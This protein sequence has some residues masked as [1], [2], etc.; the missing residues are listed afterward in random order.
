MATLP[1]AWSWIPPRHVWSNF[2]RRW[3]CLVVGVFASKVCTANGVMKISL[4]FALLGFP[5]SSTLL[6]WYLVFQSS[7]ESSDQSEYGY[8]RPAVVPAASCLGMAVSSSASGAR[9]R[10]ELCLKV[11]TT[12]VPAAVT[13]AYGCVPRGQWAP[14]GADMF[15][16]IDRSAC[17][18][19]PVLVV[20]R[21]RAGRTEHVQRRFRSLLANI[22]IAR[23]CGR[24]CAPRAAHPELLLSLFS[25]RGDYS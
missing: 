6:L 25:Q 16:L 13:A 2:A 3:E 7:S 20:S 1:S 22:S 11:R 17:L 9:S 12:L 23:F 15:E 5:R 18:V 4:G 19:E 21:A 14:L 24:S 8:D 10:P